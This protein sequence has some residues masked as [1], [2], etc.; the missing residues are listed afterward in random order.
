MSDTLLAKSRGVEEVLLEEPETHT[1]LRGAELQVNVSKERLQERYFD[2]YGPR[3]CARPFKG[4]WN[5]WNWTTSDELLESF[6]ETLIMVPLSA[7]HGPTPGNTSGI[8]SLDGF[9]E[10]KMGYAGSM[11][12]YFPISEQSVG[13]QVGIPTLLRMR[14]RRHMYQLLGNLI[15]AY[16]AWLYQKGAASH[17][18]GLSIRDRSASCSS[19]TKQIQYTGSIMYNNG[20]NERCCVSNW[21]KKKIIP[22]KQP[23]RPASQADRSS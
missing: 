8:I 21:K 5:M 10:D 12:G 16:L 13:R 6:P 9:W 7:I 22:A 11:A 3:V 15:L 20:R 18:N 4:S 19:L 14:V 1:A 17:N 2:S 23:P